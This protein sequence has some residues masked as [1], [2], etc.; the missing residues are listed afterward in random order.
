LWFTHENIQKWSSF[1]KW[2]SE[3]CESILNLY[4]LR[5]TF[6][7]IDYFLGHQS[8]MYVWIDIEIDIYVE[9]FIKNVY[10]RGNILEWHAVSNLISCRHQG[11]NTTF[12]SLA[13][14]MEISW[15]WWLCCDARASFTHRYL[16]FNFSSGFGSFMGPENQKSLHQTLYSL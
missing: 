9:L 13:V 16:S 1:E 2:M 3:L 7:R 11:N 6:L 4:I 12:W 10:Q 14:N 5:D 15:P 8:Q